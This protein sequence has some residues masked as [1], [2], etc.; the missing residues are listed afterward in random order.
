MN[1]PSMEEV[2]GFLRDNAHRQFRIDIETDSTIGAIIQQDQKNITELLSGMTAFMQGVAPAVQ[3]GALPMSAAKAIL[4]SAVRR[5]KMG[6]EVEDELEKIPDALPPP[7]GNGAAEAEK[8]KA[9]IDAEKA[10][11]QAEK[12]GMATQMQAREGEFK[13]KELGMKVQE[14]AM[15]L[16]VKEQQI[17]LG[18]TSPF[19]VGQAPAHE[20]QFAALLHLAPWLSLAPSCQVL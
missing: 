5:F 13:I 16:D 1:K 3:S 14:K 12:S 7:P 2:F 4:L 15:A 9:Q 10:Q 18:M 11:M 20:G 17:G 8:M 19:L 6:S